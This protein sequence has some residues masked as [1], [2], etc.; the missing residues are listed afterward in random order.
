LSIGL[1]LL[2]ISLR[3]KKVPEEAELRMIS[4]GDGI[5]DIERFT[6]ILL[7]CLA[8]EFDRNLAV[9]NWLVVAYLSEVE[10]TIMVY[11]HSC[12]LSGRSADL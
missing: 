4:Y 7:T 3:L 9:S 10:V 5:G 12:W 11:F 8:A 1:L 2:C 6:L